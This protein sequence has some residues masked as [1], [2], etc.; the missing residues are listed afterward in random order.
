MKVQIYSRK[1][2]EKLLQ[3]DFPENTAVISFYDPPSK[4]TGEVFKPV[5]Y[6]GKAERVFTIPIHDIDIEILEDYGLTFDTYFPE[7]N[8]LAEYIQQ[9]YK[10]G[11]DIICQCE[12]G[13]SR[14]AACAAAILQYYYN[15]GISIFADYRYYPNQL[16]YNKIKNALDKGV[17]AMNKITSFRDEYRFLS[18]FYQCP[19]EYRGLT[20]PNAEAAFQ[21]QKCSND[22]DKIKYTLQKNPVRVKQMGKKEPNL[23]ANWD[24][25]SYDIMNEILH[26][27]FSDPELAEKLIATGNAHL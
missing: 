8:S 27:K 5:D 21:A 9:A 26:A 7:V 1:A 10:D 24:T 18:N 4:R 14:S 12:Y 16:V 22:E 15:D 3:G 25:I 23:P 19:F 17:T 20:Y 2:I 6:K 13:Q 11:L